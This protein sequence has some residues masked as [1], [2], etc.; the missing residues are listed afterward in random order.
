MNDEIR[1][2]I[3]KILFLVGLL[4]KRCLCCN[5][6]YRCLTSVV[7]LQAIFYQRLTIFLFYYYFG[8]EKL[9]KSK[10]GDK[11]SQERF[12]YT[13]NTC[14]PLLL[15]HFLQK[16]KNIFSR[17]IFHLIIAQIKNIFWMQKIHFDLV[18][19]NLRVKK[20]ILKENGRI[21]QKSV[22]CFFVFFSKPRPISWVSFIVLFTVETIINH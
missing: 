20:K 1:N 9:L 12:I 7:H 11:D 14:L 21:H 18:L 2:F 3:K 19:K 22:I 5:F 16:E 15:M 10:K 6:S 8:C 4:I 13:A 17:D